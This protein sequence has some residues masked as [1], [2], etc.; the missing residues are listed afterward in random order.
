M[1]WIIASLFMFVFSVILYVLIRQASLLK[2][3]N[4]LIN[5]T[6][7]LIPLF[8]YIPICI[9]NKIKFIPSLYEFVILILLGFFCSYLG[10]K[11]SLKSIELAPNPRYSLII[12]KSYVVL[13]TLIAVLFFHSPL[14]LNSALGILLIIVFSIIIMIG[15]SNMK[16]S[17]F[18][19][20]PLSFGAFFAWGILTI[21]MKYLF[22]IGI[23]TIQLLT[24]LAIIVSLIVVFEII[25]SKIPLRT[26]HIKSI[27]LL[28]SI[29]VFSG[30]FNYFMILAL[31]ITPNIGY[32]SAINT[33][34]ISAVAICSYLFFHDELTITKLFGISGVIAG[35]ILLLVT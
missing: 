2:I 16:K 12:S 25:V 17:H 15:K 9:Q 23:N 29:G 34:S 28:L 8:L 35:L 24:L 5:L 33:A 26:L 6:S 7:F 27:A 21:G 32:V 1:N 13:T 30:L 11:A 19:W 18:L 3:P 31:S 4:P 20:L 14:P 10:N 22:T